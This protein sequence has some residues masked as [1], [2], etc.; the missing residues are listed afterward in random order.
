MF[1]LSNTLRP[2]GIL[3]RELHAGHREKI[4]S[5]LLGLSEEDR[6]LRF[7]M[8]TSDEVIS[9]YIEKIDFLN[10]SIF[11][12]FD[13]TLQLV[14]FAHLAYPLS[15]NSSKNKTAEFGVSVSRSGRGQGVGSA[16]FKRAAIHARNTQIEILYV[17]CLS[18]NKVMMHIAK[19][20]EMDIEFAYGEADA[21]LRLKPATNASIVSEAVQAQAADIDYAIKRN[22]KQSK[23]IFSNFWPFSTAATK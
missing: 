7:G 21:Y 18:S 22:V 10:D 16:L 13:S 5:H 11:G 3:V 2:R 14:G 23:L 9:S 15:S 1:N 12:V 17:H 20:A 6:T 19:K 8:H 4:K